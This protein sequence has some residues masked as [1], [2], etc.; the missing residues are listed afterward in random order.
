MLAVQGA[1]PEN[2]GPG[3]WNL[4]LGILNRLLQED[5]MANAKT[6]YSK[7]VAPVRLQ[8]LT[9]RRWDMLPYLLVVLVLLTSV[10]IFHV[11]SRVKMI[12]LNLQISELKRQTKDQQQEYNRLNLEVA[13]LKT[14]ARIEA[15]AKG[16]LGM[17]LPTDQQVVVVK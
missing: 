1:T 15:L 16:E 3:T 8:E 14:P 13:S 5:V 10:S 7:V 11:W 17:G 12:D 2:P 4:E 6:A 9:E